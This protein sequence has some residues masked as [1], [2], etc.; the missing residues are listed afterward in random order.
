MLA[1]HVCDGAVRRLVHGPVIVG[2]PPVLADLEVPPRAGAIVIIVHEDGADCRAP[3]QRFIADVLRANRF[4]TLSIGLRTAEECAGHLPPPDMAEASQRIRRVMDWV[5]AHPALRH[6]CLA[7]MGIADA[8]PACIAAA[9]LPEE[10]FVHSMVLVDGE[11]DITGPALPLLD[12]PTLL[13]AGRT[14]A[15]ALARHLAITESLEGGDSGLSDGQ[16]DGRAPGPH[17]GVANRLHRVDLI[18]NTTR[19]VAEPGALESIACA[20]TAWF[21]RTLPP[22]RYDTPSWIPGVGISSG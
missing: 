7:L 22:P 6:R 13:L 12:V 3:G 5:A 14:D 4:C 9:R 10:P 19:P 11:L 18:R 15:L 16:Q 2:E 20:T 17:D 1:D 21:G 8:V